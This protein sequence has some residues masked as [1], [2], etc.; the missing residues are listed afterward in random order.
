[1]GLFLVYSVSSCQLTVDVS[2]MIFCSGDSLEKCFLNLLLLTD[3]DEFP[4]R[5][6]DHQENG[7]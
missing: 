7:L 6:M 5:V 1:M 4:T 2:I 3:I